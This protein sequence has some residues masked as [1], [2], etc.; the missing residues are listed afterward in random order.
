VCLQALERDANRRFVSCAEFASALERAALARGQLAT[1]KDVADYV[2]DVVGSDMESHRVAIRQWLQ[3]R[4]QS[5]GPPASVPSLPPSRELSSVTL[6]SRVPP[7]PPS[8]RGS[9]LARPAVATP[10][11]ASATHSGV[12][13]APAARRNKLVATSFV[14]LLLAGIGA[15]AWVVTS[16]PSAPQPSP[17]LGSVAAVQ[18]ASA[19][20][21]AAEPTPS[22]DTSKPVATDENVAPGTAISSDELPPADDETE[23]E[24]AA[25]AEKAPAST[26]PS[27]GPRKPA[28]TP[29]AKKKG[30]SLPNLDNPYQ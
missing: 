23:S 20:T 9:L 17:T 12:I 3:L 27:R 28:R 19:Q 18:S 6:T 21:A 15:A 14:L 16:Q 2:Q 8:S 29:P 10:L 11:P 1:V 24:S 22:E 7:P 30:K 4:E 13:V 25:A 26:A 5:G